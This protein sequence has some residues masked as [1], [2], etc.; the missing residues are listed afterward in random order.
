[1]MRSQSLVR[2]RCTRSS[3]EERPS[4]SLRVIT[5]TRIPLIRA[6]EAWSC[7]PVSACGLPVIP[8]QAIRMPKSSDRRS[9][10][11]MKT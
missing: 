3:V 6:V 8:S 1:M 9:I 5:M 7:A 2:M 4:I 10:L 11:A